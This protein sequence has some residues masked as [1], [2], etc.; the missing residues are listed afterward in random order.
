[1]EEDVKVTAVKHDK[2][3]PHM[4]LVPP[5]ALWEVGLAMTFGADKYDEDNYL[6]GAGFKHRRLCSALMRHTLKYLSGEDI[7]PESGL[8][9]LAH[10][11]ATVMMLLES[12]LVG[13][14]S[15]DRYKKG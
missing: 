11:G 14:G 10:A 9:H 1:M 8:H 15:D 13:A 7:D 12:I 2:G 6:M 4:S 3:K 5:R